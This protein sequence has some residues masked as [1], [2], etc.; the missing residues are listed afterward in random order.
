MLESWEPQVETVLVRNPNYWGE[1][2]Y[3]DRVIIA[4]IAEAAT[5]KTALESGDIDIAL[6][7]TLN[8][9][10]SL[11]AN[12]N[13]GLFQATGPIVHFLLMNQNPDVGGPM[14]DPL[15]QLA[16]RYALD[17]AGYQ[18]LWGGE[19]PASVIPVGFGAAYGSDRA[20][21]RDLERAA[22]LLDEAGYPDPDG[23]EGPEPRFEV[24]LD[25]PE[26][27]FQG[28]IMGDNAE[29]VAADLAEVGIQVTLNP[30]EVQVSLEGYRAG[31]QGF[32]YWFW[33]PDYI[34]PG[35]YIVFLPERLVGLRA[36]WS[37][38]R[39]D[40]TVL[41][42]RDRAEVETDPD[43]RTQ[44][45]AEMQ[46]Y[47]QQNGPWAPFIQPGVQIAYRSDIEGVVYHIQWLID[48]AIL[49]RSM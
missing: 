4:N 10:P 39:G 38:D 5:Q 21:T 22:E 43:T 14:S 1:A 15:V 7:L 45:F 44:I 6:D 37:E 9:V 35:D 16:V 34:D 17:Y 20:F 40:E 25:Y 33:G 24:T 27:S 31:T 41:D 3:F 46:D 30:G 36:Q 13:V 32:A 26:F 29:K 28:V 47:L 11:E 19:T 49:S 48:V 2:P 8:D 12:E 18:L 23:P 42:I